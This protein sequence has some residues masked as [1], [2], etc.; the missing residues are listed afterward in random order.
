MESKELRVNL[1][2]T[3][4]MVSGPNLNTLKDSGQ[5]TLVVYVAQVLAETRY[6]AMAAITG[7]I[8][9]VVE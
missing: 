6:Y 3:K 5:N 8:R 7:Y 9:N 2:K 1:A 4:I